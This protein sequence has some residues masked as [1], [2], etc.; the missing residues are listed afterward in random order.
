M[1]GGLCGWLPLT[2]LTA[3]PPA[4]SKLMSSKSR[5]RREGDVPSWLTDSATNASDA[6]F[7]IAFCSRE[8]PLCGEAV[9]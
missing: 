7:S 6:Q 1:L 9:A 5:P 2:E 3:V 4:S 8:E